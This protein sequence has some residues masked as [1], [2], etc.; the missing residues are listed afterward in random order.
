MLYATY[1]KVSE[2]VTSS[3]H[4]IVTDAWREGQAEMLVSVCK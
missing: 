4:N 2:A 1:W 3:S